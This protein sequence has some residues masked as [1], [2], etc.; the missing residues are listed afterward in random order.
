MELTKD[1]IL[2]LLDAL[3]EKLKADNVH[4]ELTL[5]GGTV[6]ALVFDSRN[7]TKDID[8]AM[9]PRDT[10][11]E[12]ASVIAQEENLPFDWLNEAVRC[13]LFE[14]AE[15]R[16]VYL[17]LSNLL[18]YAAS[19]KYML[20]LKLRASRL[21]KASKDYEDIK[22]LLDYLDVKDVASA[23]DIAHEYIPKNLIPV[24]ARAILDEIFSSDSDIHD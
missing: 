17:E 15:D 18:I 3:N 14:G 7:S 2:S 22:F 9:E 1:R 10:L 23:L 12:Y 5:Y 21:D 24:E 20:A 6:M 8:V 4:G 19:P 13:Y 16:S 11:K